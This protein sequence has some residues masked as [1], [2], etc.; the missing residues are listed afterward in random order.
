MES[1]DVLFDLG[2]INESEHMAH[3]ALEV[4]GERPQTLKRL[5]YIQVLKGRPE[6]ARR[7]LALLERSLLHGRWARR[8]L[9]QLE[10]DP[11]LSAVPL[12]ASR[13]KLMVVQDSD[14][15]L[16]LETMLEQ[17]LERNRRNRM[18][19]EYLMAHYLL[20]GQLDKMV[21]NLHRFDGFDYPHLPRHCEEALAIYLETTGSQEP[22]LGRHKVRPEI[23]RRYH[24]FME[25]LRQFRGDT[26]A[27]FAAL[28]P[29]FGATYFFYHA[30][31]HNDLSCGQ[32]RS[33]R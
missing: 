8:L 31:G 10:A 30:F 14:D 23:R 27:A 15:K 17:L 22:N 26:P 18:A 32:S 9:R 6:A 5:V 20:T 2:R 7:F 24:E 16:D 1:S 3:E 11:T 21:A 19:F 13:R 4:L 25:R 28:H 12:V 29:D 33:S